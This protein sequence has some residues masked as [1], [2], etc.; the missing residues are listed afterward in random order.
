M[1]ALGTFEL[2]NIYQ[3]DCVELLNKIP[4]N[5]V[6]LIFADP[7]YNLQLNGDL[8]RPDLSKVDAVDDEWD[9]FDS[10]GEYDQFTNQWLAECH[11][12]LKPTGSIWVIGSYH[13]IFRVGTAL[14]NIGFWILNDII[15]VKSNPMPNFKG[16]RFNNAHET[17]IWATKS[18]SSKFTFHYHSMKVM[19]DDLQMRS[20]W[21]IPICQGNERIKVNGMKAHSTQKPE[22][23]LYRVLISSSNP[24]DVVLDPF[25]GSGTTAAVAKRLGRRYIAFERDEFY[26][27]VARERLE[28]ITPVDGKIT[29]YPIENR[30]PKVPFNSLIVEDYIRLGELLYSKDGKV[31]ATV[32]ADGT[33]LH[34]GFVGSI[35]KVSAKILNRSNNNGW[36]FWYVMR[37]NKLV[38][39]DTLRYEYEK[40]YIKRI[41]HKL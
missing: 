25:S 13:N 41:Q 34:D 29:G 36:S 7:P 1:T 11:R 31:S 5:S 4:D 33:L 22:E 19:N 10:F 26:I 21:V 35:H 32:N 30:I 14:Q 16:T 8:Y 3:G 38:S 9:K 39:I 6:D 27:R 17:L 18:K 20:D 24:G 40:K 23:L 37:D 12:V 2:N 28:K 15:W